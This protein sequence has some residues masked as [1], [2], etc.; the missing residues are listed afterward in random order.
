MKAKWTPTTKL[1]YF[2]VIGYLEENWTKRE[3]LNFVNDVERVLKQ[4]SKDPYMFK[5]LRNQ[6]NVRKGLIT[7]HNAIYYRIR[8]KKKEI[9]LITFWDNRQD[10]R[11]SHFD[12]F[13]NTAVH[14]ANTNLLTRCSCPK[15]PPN[16]A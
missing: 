8:P 14:T 3:M 7:K 15:T 11:R 1:T 10:P 5:P 2:K 16:I 12:L 13:N 4:L 9:E 6:K